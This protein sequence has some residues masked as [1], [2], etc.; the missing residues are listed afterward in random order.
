MKYL[1]LLSG[2]LP[3]TCANCSG[4]LSVIGNFPETCGYTIDRSI[5]T[6]GT[7]RTVFAN[8]DETNC[9]VTCSLHQ[10]TC[11]TG[12]KPSETYFILGDAASEY[13]L[14]KTPAMY[15]SAVCYQC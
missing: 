12:T 6:E 8:S 2:L 13:S 3:L 11:G 15:S 14:T 9:P 5:I 4:T 1:A 7:W 10:S